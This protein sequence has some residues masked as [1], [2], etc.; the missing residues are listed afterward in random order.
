MEDNPGVRRDRGLTRLLGD[1]LPNS[2]WMRRLDRISFLGAL[3]AQPDVLSRTSRLDHAYSVAHL[4]MAVADALVPSPDDRRLLVTAAFVHDVGHYPLSH[5]AEPGFL[6]V[7]GVGHQR[8]TEWIVRGNGPIP[9]SSSLGPLLRKGGVDPNRVWDVVS[10]AP[11]STEL[12]SWLLAATINVDTID[13]VG[14][15]AQAFGIRPLETPPALV[16]QVD[17]RAWI[18]KDGIAWVDRF[19]LLKDRVYREVINRPSNVLAEAALC[20]RIV[21]RFQ[22][23]VLD[24]ILALDDDELRRVAGAGAAI[25]EEI[26]R[27]EAEFQVVE[28][29]SRPA[30]WGRK[31]KRYWVDVMVEPE[32][33]GL[34]HD[35]WA[36]RYRHETRALS[37]VPRSSPASRIPGV[38]G[39]SRE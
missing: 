31:S 17:G 36:K 6:R 10:G 28:D 15:A 25:A 8:L 23:S 27:W 18:R 9:L 21:Q 24:R 20:D 5:S 29:G 26:A 14:R 30:A 1:E 34:P 12:T 35:L 32:S 3:D 2:A 16:V 38:T 33:A 37:V 39:L 7:T 22:P 19:W 11:G 13:G 4:A